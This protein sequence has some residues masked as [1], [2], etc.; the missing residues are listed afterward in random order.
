MKPEV[1]S[2]VDEIQASVLIRDFAYDPNL[3]AF[4]GGVDEGCIRVP[5]MTRISSHLRFMHQSDSS[6]FQRAGSPLSNI[7]QLDEQVIFDSP[8]EMDGKDYLGAMY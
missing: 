7:Q 1:S 2:H 3:E 6:R 4:T 5:K 8:E